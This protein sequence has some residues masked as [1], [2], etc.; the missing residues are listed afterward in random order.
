LAVPGDEI[1]IGIAGA[2]DND[3]LAGGLHRVLQFMDALATDIH[4]MAK[5]RVGD[6][7]DATTVIGVDGKGEQEGAGGTLGLRF[8]EHMVYNSHRHRGVFPPGHGFRKSYDVEARAAIPGL[9]YLCPDYRTLPL[10]TLPP[11]DRPPLPWALG[12]G[13]WALWFNISTRVKA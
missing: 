7:G 2:L 12:A 9:S 13:A 6:P 4:F 3:Q 1:E 5:C 8:T 10:S 11:P